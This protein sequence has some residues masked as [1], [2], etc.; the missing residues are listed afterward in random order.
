ME[1]ESKQATL[2]TSPRETKAAPNYLNHVK[3]LNRKLIERNGENDSPNV[4]N[5]PALQNRR[6]S[7]DMKQFKSANNSP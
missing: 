7:Q 6:L 4:R 3:D 5:L 1:R 2:K